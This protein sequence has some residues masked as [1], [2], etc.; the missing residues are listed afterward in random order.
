MAKGCAAA[1]AR[2]DATWRQLD[3]RAAWV[4][5]DRSSPFLVR[6]SVVDKGGAPRA[7][8][9]WLPTCL[10]GARYGGWVQGKQAQDVVYVAGSV[11]TA[12]PRRPRNYVSVPAMR[13]HP[14]LDLIHSMLLVIGGGCG[15]LVVG[16]W[17][18]QLCS[19]ASFI[20]FMQKRRAED[21]RHW[22][23]GGGGGEPLGYGECGLDCSLCTP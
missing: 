19:F 20:V 22:L 15:G 3:S 23:G 11:G 7:V 4:G 6:G 18:E 21:V 16:P 10:L 5:R 12:N 8:V 13:R 14:G 2:A 17:R 1:N 9:A